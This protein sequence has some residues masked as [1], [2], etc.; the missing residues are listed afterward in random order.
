MAPP[1][2][3]ER[4]AA[5]AVGARLERAAERYLSE[6]GLRTLARNYRCRGGELDLVMQHGD[7]IVFVEVRYRRS[8]AYGSAAE[9]VDR[10]KQQRLLRAAEH[11]LARHGARAGCPC[12]FDVVALHGPL[13]ALELDWIEGAFSA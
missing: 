3:S 11:Y 6:R 12:R 7:S 10:R 13:D 4:E 5:T 9:S 1:P 8:R 2:A